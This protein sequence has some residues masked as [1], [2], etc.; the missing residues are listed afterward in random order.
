ML[1]MLLMSQAEFARRCGVS[2]QAICRFVRDWGVPTYGRR[3]LV[4]A[5]ELDRLYYPRIDAGAAQARTRDSYGRPW[6]PGGR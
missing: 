2:R 3:N 6:P 5:E 1:T 4:D